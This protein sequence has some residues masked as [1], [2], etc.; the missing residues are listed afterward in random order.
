MPWELFGW[1]SR[2]AKRAANPRGI[3]ACG[4]TAKE[5][6]FIMTC[7]T[8]LLVAPP[9]KQYN[10]PTLIPPAT[11]ARTD[12]AFYFLLKSDV[13]TVIAVV[14]TRSCGIDAWRDLILPV[15]A[16]DPPVVVA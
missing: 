11:H 1:R 8:T 12:S 9:P 13:L 7:I 2:H 6:P 15:A 16:L 4:K 14:V 10:T 5:N 3:F